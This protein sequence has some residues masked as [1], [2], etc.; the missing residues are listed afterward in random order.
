M[1]KLIPLIFLF[2]SC[3]KNN[4]FV[5][6]TISYSIKIDSALTQNGKNSLPID[7][8]GIYHYKLIPSSN[9]Q[10]FRVTGHLLVNGKEPYPAER[11]DWESNLYWWLRQGDTIAYI[12]KSYINYYTGQYTIVKLP[13]MISNKDYLIPTTNPMC[14]SGDG[15]E[16]NAIVAPISEMKGDT[17]VLKGTHTKSNKII[18]CK[19]ILE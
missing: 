16:I 2:Y 8:N 17:L 15:G 1:K 14:Y 3:S 11:V 9:Q 18:Y 12:T 4:D 7:A 19:I 5:N 6:K 13:P 10:P